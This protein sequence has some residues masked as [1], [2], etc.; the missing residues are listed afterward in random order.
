MAED[1]GV[2]GWP[3]LTRWHSY[4]RADRPTEIGN[5]ASGRKICQ[6]SPPS[7]VQFPRCRSAQPT[8]TMLTS[9]S[10]PVVSKSRHL[11]SIVPLQY[12]ARE[13]LGPLHALVEVV[14]LKFRD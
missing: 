8:S 14:R 2:I 3:G 13:I 5:C 7:S 9:G 11:S 1:S 4:G 6:L 10:S 12:P